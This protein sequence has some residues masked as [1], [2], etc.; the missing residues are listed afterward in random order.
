MGDVSETCTRN[1]SKRKAST[2]R[3]NRNEDDVEMG[4][5]HMDLEKFP[6]TSTFNPKK[7]S[8]GVDMEDM[9]GNRMSGLLFTQEMPFYSPDHM[10]V[11]VVQHAQHLEVEEQIVVEKEGDKQ[12]EEEEEEEEEEDDDDDDDDERKGE[13]EGEGE[14]EVEKEEQVPLTPPLNKRLRTRLQKSDGNDDR[15]VDER[16]KGEGPNQRWGPSSDMTYILKFFCV[17]DSMVLQT[18]DKKVATVKVDHVGT[19]AIDVRKRLLVRLVL[20]PHNQLRD[21]SI[22]AVLLL[23]CCCTVK[24]SQAPLLGM[25][26]VYSSVVL[27]VEVLRSSGFVKYCTKGH[28]PSFL[29]FIYSAASRY[30]KLLFSS[31][32]AATL[33]SRDMVSV[34]LFSR[35]NS[36]VAAIA[37]VYHFSGCGHNPCC[38]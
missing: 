24:L 35:D 32:L 38:C 25:D 23:F 28:V 27:A 30:S 2:K 14:Q 19:D 11:D 9:D 33:F 1:P 34:A 3:K 37:A 17:L 18:T 15:M 12:G 13:G 21:V 29:W 5:V 31:A 26:Y 7:V 36:D 8:D 22:T 4:D 20:S 16:R 10:M 6:S